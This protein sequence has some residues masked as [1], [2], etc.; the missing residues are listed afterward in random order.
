MR[1]PLDDVWPRL[2][3]DLFRRLGPQRY[4][5][6]I[7]HARPVFFDDEVFR[8]Q[9][10]DSDVKDK[11]ESVL[12]AVVTRAAQLVTNRNVR[13]R[14]TVGGRNPSPA[15]ENLLGEGLRP[16]A[17]T[18]GTFV[19][20]TGNRAALEAAR[21]FAGRGRAAPRILLIHGPSGLGKTHLLRAIAAAIPADTAF[22]TVHLSCEQFHRKFLCARQRGQ[23][24]AFRKNFRIAHTFLLDDLHLL[25]GKFEAQQALLDILLALVERGGGA[26]LTSEK[27]LKELEGFS[28]PFRSRLRPV[29]EVDVER[30]DASS[31]VDVLRAC[32]PPGLSPAVLK[33]IV[34]HV[35]SSHKDQLLCLSR[36]LRRRSPSLSAARAIV[37][38]FL[39]QWSHGLTYEDVARAAAKSYGIP[40]S[41]IYSPRRTRAAAQARQ[42]CF[43]VSRKLL[44][45][46]FAG[47]GAHFGG[48]DH[49][50]VIQACRKL[51][52]LKG[53]ARGRLCRMEQGLASLLSDL[54]RN[55]VP[56]PVKIEA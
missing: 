50:T 44:Q 14:F 55:D 19:E 51:E 45:R 32:A 47:I 7:R 22:R 2:N 38:E 43:Y 23:E 15:E 29:R 24:E 48:R 21:D 8:F 26:A 1:S 18:F 6:W 53:H 25:Y 34:A 36:L 12:K 3:R 39:N 31:A 30:P 28:R 17:Q 56:A 49:A 27:P 16:A 13:V 10:E 54:G 9:F 41:E 40:V 11:I 4:A 52:R 5:L 35:G 46:P 33:Y 37:G 20:G 42:A